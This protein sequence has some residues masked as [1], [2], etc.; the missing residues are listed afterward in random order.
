MIQFIGDMISFLQ[1]LSLIDYILYFAVLILIVLVISLIYII[2]SENYETEE[3]LEEIKPIEIKE[4]EPNEIN[5]EQIVNTIDENPKPL[6]DMTSYEE[7]QEEKAI[8]SYE[9]LINSAKQHPINY[10]EEE[11]IDNEIKVKKINLEQ[12]TNTAIQEDMPKFNVK[13]F[14]YE[15]EEAFLKALKQ[16]NEILN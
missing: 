8:I 16:L 13:L 7:E 10:D 5:L 4:P 1:S 9:E 2:K 12:L 3:F 11:L 6:I 14:N 15:R